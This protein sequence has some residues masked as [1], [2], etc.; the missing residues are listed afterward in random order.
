M[1]MYK[2]IYEKQILY[3]LNKVKKQLFIGSVNA[4]YSFTTYWP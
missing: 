4:Q 1:N 2:K 3:F